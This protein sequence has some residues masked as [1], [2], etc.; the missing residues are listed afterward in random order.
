MKVKRQWL[1]Y[2]IAGWLG[3]AFLVPELAC[4]AADP[5]CTLSWSIW[6]VMAWSPLVEWAVY[7]LIV[8]LAWHFVVDFR[9]WRRRG[10]HRQ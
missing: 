4:V 5:S 8:W 2:W 10:R 6:T 1:V 7:G 9:R 3:L